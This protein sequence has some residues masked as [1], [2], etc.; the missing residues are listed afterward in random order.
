[1]PPKYKGLEEPVSLLIHP[2]IDFHHIPVVDRDYKIH[3]I[4]DE[5]DI[6]EMYFWLE[7]KYIDNSNDIQLQESIFPT[8]YFL[9]A[10]IPLNSS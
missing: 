5:F 3:E 7:D 2:P 1:M 4:L 10:T 8:I 9:V 6:F